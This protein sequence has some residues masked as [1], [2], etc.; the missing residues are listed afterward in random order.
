MTPDVTGVRAG[1]FTGAMSQRPLHGNVVFVL[2]QQG[3]TVTAVMNLPSGL[4][5]RACHP[6][7]CPTIRAVFPRRMPTVSRTD[8]T[9]PAQGEEKL[10]SIRTRQIASL[11]STLYRA[12]ITGG[13]YVS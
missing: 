7:C 9:S 6:S 13:A 8:V 1:S 3:A 12:D 4:A 2:Q 11:I 5:H 10:L